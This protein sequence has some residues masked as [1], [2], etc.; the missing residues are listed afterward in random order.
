MCL[1]EVF[2]SHETCETQISSYF[3][4]Q[5]S[6]HLT[7][8]M[9]ALALK[10]REIKEAIALISRKIKGAVAPRSSKRKKEV[11]VMSH[12]YWGAIGPMDDCA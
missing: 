9:V 2:R 11:T 10:S 3:I 12:V 5:E 1:Y 4:A 8:K 6:R 7:R